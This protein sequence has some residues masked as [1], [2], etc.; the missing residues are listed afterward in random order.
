MANDIT[1]TDKSDNKYRVFEKEY[2]R[3]RLIVLNRK[4]PAKRRLFARHYTKSFNPRSAAIAAGCPEKAAHATAWKWRQDPLVQEYI[5]LLMAKTMSKIELDVDR[6]LLEACRIAFGDIT[7]VVHWDQDGMTVI[8]SEILDKNESAAIAEVVRQE[9][10]YGTNTKVKM[11]D[12]KPALEL[13]ARYL[14]IYKD[15]VNLGVNATL[16]QILE[17]IDG[18]TKGLPTN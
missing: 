8:P 17:D 10:A 6:V 2:I 4:I 13:L 12:K 15:N 18:E 5:E 14:D 11:H 1:T 3:N 16:R 9:T 7:D